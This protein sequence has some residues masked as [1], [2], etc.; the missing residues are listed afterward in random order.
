M[1]SIAEDRD[2]D[3]LYQTVD[4]LFFRGAFAAVDDSISMM[5]PFVNSYK[6]SYLI[7]MLTVSGWAKRKLPSRKLLFEAVDARL[8]RECN[9]ER[10]A[11]LRGL[12]P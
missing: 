7:G 5:L 2:L 12:E 4:E 9:H 11:L 6:L 8:K 1:T 3:L 10:E